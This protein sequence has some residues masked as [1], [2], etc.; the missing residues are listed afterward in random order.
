MNQNSQ[1]NRAI[2]DGDVILV[3]SIIIGKANQS[4]TK[5]KEALEIV[6]SKGLHIFEANDDVLYEIDSNKES[7]NDDYWHRLTGHLMHNF[8][9][10]RCE[11]MLK[12]RQYLD[13]KRQTQERRQA[14]RPL[15]RETGQKKSFKN[16]LI[17]KLSTV[18]KIIA[19]LFRKPL[20]RIRKRSVH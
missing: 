6:S 12:V 10:E 5:A 4:V 2:E 11:H 9:E 15:R 13:S 3:R 19:A 1:L 18:L 17:A 8:S 20:A 16:G 7:W 14:Y